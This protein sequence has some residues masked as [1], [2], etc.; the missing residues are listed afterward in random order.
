MNPKEFLD[1]I[2]HSDSKEEY[3]I[4]ELKFCNLLGRSSCYSS[5]VFEKKEPI[6]FIVPANSQLTYSDWVPENRDF[7]EDNFCS[8][9][10]NI[11]PLRLAG[12]IHQQHDNNIKVLID[13]FFAMVRREGGKPSHIIW[14]NKSLPLYDGPLEWV[15][16]YGK[17][18]IIMSD[19]LKD[20]ILFIQADTWIKY[21]STLVCN[22]PGWN[23][24][25]FLKGNK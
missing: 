23:L 20:E 15:C 10:R 12:L 25:C 21:P 18:P 7:K 11:D 14:P 5:A 17:A 24:R 4:F 3:I 6:N 9:N 1:V 16:S 22:M 8:V 13:D 2:P 19:D